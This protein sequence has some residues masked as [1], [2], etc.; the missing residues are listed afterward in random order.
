MLDAAF[1]GLQ[2]AN[3]IDSRGARYT[4]ALNASDM[5]YA[6]WFR[7]GRFWE[8]WMQSAFDSAC[9]TTDCA[10]G[11]V[12]D[13]GANIGTHTLYLARHHAS[14]LWAFEPQRT[15]FSQLVVQ[16]ALNQIRHVWPVNVALSARS[17]LLA[18]TPLRPNNPGMRAVKGY[19]GPPG[20]P[21]RNHT[22]QG[23]HSAHV[24]SRTPTAP[25]GAR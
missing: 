21:V 2:L 25:V 11:V 7:K 20:S 23:S 5:T 4:V 6:K 22:N 24:P 19:P 13:L 1:G 3:A 18:M 12:L 15:L 9:T 17:S 16:L 14:E 8:E 10:D